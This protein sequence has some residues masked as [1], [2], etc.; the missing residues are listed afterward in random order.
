[1]GGRQTKRSHHEAFARSTCNARADRGSDHRAGSHLARP[2][3]SSALTLKSPPRVIVQYAHVK[4][5]RRTGAA[6]SM[7][8]DPALWLTGITAYHAPS[9]TRPSQRVS[10]S[11]TTT[12]VGTGPSPAHLPRSVQDARVTVLTRGEPGIPTT[13]ISVAEFAQIVQGKNPRHRQLFEPKAGFWLRVLPPLRPR[14]RP[15]TSSTS[16]REPGGERRRRP[17]MKGLPC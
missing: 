13:T 5:L 16:P 8:V 2:A 15:S 12:I 3:S 4:S 14:P 17:P 7:R 1:M 9:R 11:R 6:S 10:R